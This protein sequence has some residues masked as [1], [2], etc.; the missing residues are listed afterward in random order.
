MSINKFLK[1]F[2]IHVR[3]TTAPRS[4]LVVGS[5][6]GLT[7]LGKL[8]YIGIALKL[9]SDHQPHFPARGQNFPFIDEFNLRWLLFYLEFR[10]VT[11]VFQEWQTN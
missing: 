9:A 3:L 8:L 4:K 5:N 10:F 1:I 6:K 2:Y 7:F 11:S